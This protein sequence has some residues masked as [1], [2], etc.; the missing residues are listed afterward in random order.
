MDRREFVRVAGAALGGLAGPGV[1]R[2]AD[3][4]AKAPRLKVGEHRRYLV[5]Q[6]GDP[7]FV[8]GDTPWFLQKLPIEDVRLVMDDRKKKGFN[9]LFLELLDDSRIPSRDANGAVAF[10]PE[11]DIT[12]PVEAYWR[13]A[14]RVLDEAAA[15][16]FFVILS[17]LWYGYGDGLWM[18]HVT[19]ESAAVYGAFLGERYKRRTNLMWMHVGDRNP[20]DRLA[21]C[22]R[23]LARQIKK[24]APHHLHTAHLQHEFASARTFHADPWL[25]V[26]MAYTYGPAYTHVRPEY[27]RKDPVR[28]VVLG[29]TGYEGEPNAI[30]LLPDAKAGDLWTPY[31]IRRNAYWAILSGAVG[32]CGGTKLWLYEKNWK[33]VL[34]ARS[35]T[36][37]GLIGKAVAGR[38]WWKLVPDADHTF[39]T[40]GYGTWTGADY[41]TAAVAPNAGLGMVYLPT[42]RAVT[43]DL[44][45]LKGRLRARW[46]DPTAGTTR[47]IDGPLAN[48]TR[49]FTPPG[50][51]AAGEPDWLLI[52]ESA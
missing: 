43:A 49:E 5:D 46:F 47:D 30:H 48:E 38:A 35:T 3:P 26:N 44:G 51:N 32:Y 6:N 36:E 33:D 21:E 13:Y 1:A 16:G 29:E 31:R 4:E 18:H 14:D 22:A 41:A 52:V 2:A 12:K 45:R 19:P 17:D 34:Q 37:A 24:A 8:L 42:P 15:R 25:D 11:K 7:F 27:Q 40:A 23:V 28:P 20:D 50:K 9:T 10:D 39:A